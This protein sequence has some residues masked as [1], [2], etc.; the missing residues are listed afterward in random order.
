MSYGWC[1][2]CS[3]WDVYGPSFDGVNETMSTDSGP[4]ISLVQPFSVISSISQGTDMEINPKP[5][6][7]QEKSSFSTQQNDGFKIINVDTPYKIE[8]FERQLFRHE[9][10]ESRRNAAFNALRELGVDIY[11]VDELAIKNT[12]DIVQHVNH[13][14]RSI[15]LDST[16]MVASSTLGPQRCLLYQ[17]QQS[18][19]FNLVMSSTTEGPRRRWEEYL[20]SFSTVRALSAFVLLLRSFPGL[21]SSK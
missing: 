13:I 4:D 7:G 18:R 10:S 9:P 15:E 16:T 19:M 6:Q 1:R 2:P 14:I 5:Q 8:Y 12:A 11:I 17:D 21:F 3:S 20:E